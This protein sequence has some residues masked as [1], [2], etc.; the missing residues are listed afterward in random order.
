MQTGVVLSVDQQALASTGLA[1]CT[2]ACTS[3]GENM[4]AAAPEASL[5]A[6]AAAVANL[7][8]EDRAKLAAMLR[9]ADRP[10]GE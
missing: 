4:N 5:E 6:L 3:D 8:P 1:A 2:S 10:D 9:L 7:S